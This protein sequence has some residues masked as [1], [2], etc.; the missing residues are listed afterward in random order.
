VGCPETQVELVDG[1]FRDRECPSAALPFAEVV[2]RACRGGEPVTG[3]SRFEQWRRPTATSFVA[4]VAEVAV[5]P[6]T[7]QVQVQKI[8]AATDVGT[9]LNPIGV[10]GQLDGALVMGLGAGL[11]EEAPLV[12]GQV[13]PAGLHEYKLPTVMDIPPLTNLLITDGQGPGP[14]GAKGV[15]ELCHLP[16]PAALANAVYDAVGVRIDTVPITAERVYQ[17]LKARKD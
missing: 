11:M 17:A 3:Y 1:M 8:V 16:L 15:S 2:A 10:G 4:Q 12:D 7:G 6:E 9:V 13:G 5:D 14:Y